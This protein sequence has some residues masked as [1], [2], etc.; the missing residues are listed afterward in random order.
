[1]KRKKGLI[2]TALVTILD[3][4]WWDSN[5][6]YCG[7]Q[8]K[9]STLNYNDYDVKLVEKDY[10]TTRTKCPHCKLVYRIKLARP[11]DLLVREYL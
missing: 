7:K 11:I 1:M 10:G 9:I 2:K 8:N 6:A 4:W 5:C 3:H